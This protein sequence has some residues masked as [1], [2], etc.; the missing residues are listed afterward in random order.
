MSSLC[1]CSKCVECYR[2]GFDA[3]KRAFLIEFVREMTP[4]GIAAHFEAAEW[5]QG[6]EPIGAAIDAG[7][8]NLGLARA[9]ERAF[10]PANGARDCCTPLPQAPTAVE[11]NVPERQPTQRRFDYCVRSRNERQGQRECH[12][13]LTPGRG[14]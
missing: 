8:N 12:P 5:I 10:P 6:S 11:P 3:G 4:D 13:R 1:L 9:L 7:L 2:R 14:P